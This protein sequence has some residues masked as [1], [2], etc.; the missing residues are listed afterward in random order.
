MDDQELERYSRSRY[1]AGRDG[2][3]D[4]MRISAA[5]PDGMRTVADYSRRAAEENRTYAAHSRAARS[6][7]AHPRRV[8]R[9]GQRLTARRGFKVAIVAL[10]AA[11]VVGAGAAF[12]YLSNISNNL[13]EGVDDDLRAALVETDMA[14]EPFYMLL[15]GSDGSADRD[16]DPE[17][18]GG[19]RSDSMM[20]ARVDPV[21]KKVTLVSVGRDIL[22]DLGGE[23]GEQKIN[24]AFFV[25]GPAAAVKAVSEL[26][27]VPI[28]H[29]AQV[30]FDGFA[31]MVDALGG[32]EV[33]V[34]MSFDDYDAGG[35]LEAGVQTLDGYH[36][37]VLCRMR[38]A[39][40]DLAAKPD[41]MRAANQRLVLAAI[42]KKVLASDIATIASTVSAMSAYVTT[43][44]EL[45]DIIGLAQVMKDLD[46][47][48]SVY[49]ASVPTTSQV[50]GD[51]WY[52]IVNKSE[53]AEMMKRIDAGLPPV[54]EAVVDEATGVVLATSGAGSTAASVDKAATIVV[55]NATD[56]AGLASGVRSKLM[57]AGF[58]NVTIGEITDSGSYPETVV[59]YDSPKL[60]LEAEGIVSA[61]GQGRAMAND[62]SYLLV[63]CDFLVIIGEDF[64]K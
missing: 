58:S 41:E 57:E 50:I 39:Y 55:K 64:S 8:A 5:D 51:G 19:Y 17:Y 11:V 20:L 3:Y 62:G 59:V 52:E 61:I 47:D 4:D 12:A 53:W 24:A 48:T 16:E 23:Y 2:F 37:L 29:Y 13:H 34:P 9:G 43:D 32:V 56:V 60:A 40:S 49:T 7:E 6:Y 15:L 36:A 28:S 30:D 22:V 18:A 42:A 54:E 27:G 31:A 25:G 38:N 46:P 26:A 21:E 63:D 33:D 1:G 44:L 14:K 45:T 35:S 10:V